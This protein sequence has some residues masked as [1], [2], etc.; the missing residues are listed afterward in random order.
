MD[1][2]EAFHK[3][4]LFLAASVALV[5]TAM[6]FAIWA[7]LLGHLGDAFGLSP[8]E[9]GEIAS[10]AFWGLA[11]KNKTISIKKKY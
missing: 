2:K 3:P 6:T 10:A 8:T 4:R 9:I 5:I 7:N 1:Q 11:C